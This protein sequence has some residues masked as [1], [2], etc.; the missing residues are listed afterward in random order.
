[1]RKKGLVYRM[2][3]ILGASI[4]L[5]QFGGEVFYAKFFR[6]D[7]DQQINEVSLKFQQVLT[8]CIYRNK[9]KKIEN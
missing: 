5:F 8:M 3:M 9:L 2:T 7:R 6:D 1:M 4:I